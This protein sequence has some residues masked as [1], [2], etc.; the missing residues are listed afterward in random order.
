MLA[1]SARVEPTPVAPGIAGGPPYGVPGIAG[2]PALGIP[3]GPPYGMLGVPL[4]IP[5]GAPYGAALDCE[6]TEPPNPPPRA[7]P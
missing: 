7:A 4:G 3:G 1:L 5:G 2:G 6:P